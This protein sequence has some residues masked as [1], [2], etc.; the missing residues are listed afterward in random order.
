M[1]PCVYRAHIEFIAPRR[2][3][4]YSAIPLQLLSSLPS[5]PPDSDRRR[6]IL[7]RSAFQVARDGASSIV[8]DLPP[9]FVNRRE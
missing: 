5:C 1:R 6:F 4:F 8:V 9:L 7:H 3:A 2:A